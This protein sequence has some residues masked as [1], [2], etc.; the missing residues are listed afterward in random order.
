LLTFFDILLNLAC[1]SSFLLGIGKF[2][3]FSN[4]TKVFFY[5]ILF[6]LINQIAI[7]YCFIIKT[8]NI[9]FF[10]LYLTLCFFYSSY[11]FTKHIVNNIFII[12]FLFLTMVWLFYTKGINT[13]NIYVFILC[14]LF[15]CVTNSILI[16]K[17]VKKDDLLFNNPQFYIS[18]G[19]LI[20]MFSMSAPLLLMNYIT[21]SHFKILAKFYSVFSSIV[22]ILVNLFYIKA[23]LCSKKQIS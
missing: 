4:Q 13:F 19:L 10:N 11:V 7:D 8:N 15:T 14:S 3:C 5:F 23:F 17:L 21:S 16:L 20:F 18:S 2:N 6:T 9:I 12:I 22:T 1:L